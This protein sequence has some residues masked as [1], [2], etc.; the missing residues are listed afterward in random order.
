MSCWEADHSSRHITTHAPQEAQHVTPLLQQP[1]GP[2]C[3]CGPSPCSRRGLSS[4]AVT[5]SKL[6]CDT[7][8]GIR[9]LALSQIA[10]W[11]GLAACLLRSLSR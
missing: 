2:T 8:F 4:G 6:A 7:E 10:A 11:A 1:W 9:V 3:R 5:L